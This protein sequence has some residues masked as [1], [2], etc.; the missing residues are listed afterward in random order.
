[1]NTDIRLRLT[2]PCELPLIEV[3]Y[4]LVFHSAVHNIFNV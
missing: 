1:M 2:I 4:G 3:G